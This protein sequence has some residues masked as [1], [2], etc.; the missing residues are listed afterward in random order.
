[1]AVLTGLI[2]ASGLIVTKTLRFTGKSKESSAG[3]TLNANAGG[4]GL[5]VNTGD[6]NESLSKPTV[7]PGQPSVSSG[8]PTVTVWVNTKSVVYHCPNSRWYGN[9][10]NGKYATQKEAQSEGY[11]P[12]YGIVC[13][14]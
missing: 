12:A 2:L 7:S 11:R 4:P 6:S 5:E 10:K 9:T 8:N 13:S 1:M 3:P 14:Q